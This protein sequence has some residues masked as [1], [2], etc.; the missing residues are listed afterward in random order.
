MKERAGQWATFSQGYRT[1]IAL[2]RKEN[3]NQKVKIWTCDDHAIRVNDD[4]KDTIND[5]GKVLQQERVGD[6]AAI[7]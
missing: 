2:K 4:Q 5:K 6:T 1:L 3:E 7:R